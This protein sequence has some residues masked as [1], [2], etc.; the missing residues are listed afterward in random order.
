MQL[1]AKL[2]KQNIVPG[3]RQVNYLLVKLK[4]PPMAVSPTRQPLV[5]GLA[6]D[7][8]WSMKGE[9]MEAT[10]EAASAMVN[11]LTRY[12]Y[13]TVIAYSADVQ[14]VLPLVQL[15]DKISVI[16]KISSIK[17]GTSTNLSG[18]WLQA[19]RTIESANI[20]N[21]YKRVIL[22]TDGQAT[23]GIQD[24]DQFNQ[25]ASDH[26]SR[27][28]STTTIGFGEDINEEVLRKISLSGGGNFYYVENPEHT[29]E[30]FFKEFGDIGA[31]YAQG[32]ELK[33]KFNE[34]IKIKE[35]LNDSPHQISK[36]DNTLT[37]QPGDIR[38]DDTRGLIVAVEIDGNRDLP[39]NICSIDLSY[40]NLL[41]NMQLEKLSHSLPLKKGDIESSSDSEVVVER[42][43]A[44]AARTMINVSKLINDKEMTAAKDIL[45]AMIEKV[46]GSL[47]LSPEMLNP[48]MVRL[49]S[50][51]LKLKENL[52]NVSK[53]FMAA[54][55]NMYKS[56]EVI[57]LANIDVHNKI[58]EYKVP[59][60]IDLYKCPEIKSM[61][62]N[63]L[64]SGYRF[65]IFDLSNTRHID[66]SGIGA[67][68]QIVGWLRRR[69]GEF[70]VTELTDGV[71]KI[72][73]LTR[74]ENHI[75]VASTLEEANKIIQV[76]ID[77]LTNQS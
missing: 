1:E 77:S 54:G 40:Y 33:L 45:M 3:L 67:F 14:I 50:M 24:P 5:I 41:E 31:L 16:D 22:L 43:I 25:I 53:H 59:G 75:R 19:L 36:A 32:I 42:L 64:N 44:S 71:K 9:K 15:N 39:E 46:Q 37:I 70:I 51:E 56:P 73:A 62:Q 28:I 58:F 57:D 65:I 29:S 72:F 4:T 74:L 52:S 61:V 66:S 6:I 27:G 23:I 68:I 49:K 47:A 35:L 7:K 69:G 21:S 2:E 30:I 48:V 38:C 18:G 17:V 11:W 8:S 76:L 63:Q 26:L 12:D 20:S 60:D 55:S 10:I 13:L 34:G